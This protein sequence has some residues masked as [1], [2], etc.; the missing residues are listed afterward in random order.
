[1][2]TLENI[3]VGQFQE[4]YKIQKS[5]QDQYDKMTES[6]ALLTDKTVREVEDLSIP[7]FNKLASQI[8]SLWDQYKNI[9]ERQAPKYLVGHGI[10]YEPGKLTRGQYVTCMH[11]VKGDM[12]ENMHL[13]MASI[14]YDPKTKKHD[15]DNHLVIAEQIQSAL[16]LDVHAS[17][18]FFYHLFTRS[19]KTLETFF[20]KR[21]I[22]EGMNP[23]VARRYLQA[24][25]KDLDGF[26]S[27]NGLPTLKE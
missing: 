9:P 18:V 21:M 24:L 1:M 7:E 25:W 8:T 5:D 15:T 23:K 16:F 4:L 10:T 12:I 20:L 26:T 11:F 3:T 13:V 19:I 6:V 2:V 14:S 27:V 17:C 22:Q